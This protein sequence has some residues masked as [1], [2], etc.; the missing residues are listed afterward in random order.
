MDDGQ[1]ACVSPSRL[2]DNQRVEPAAVTGYWQCSLSNMERV[3]DR[4]SRASGAP[5]A[6]C[7]RQDFASLAARRCR[8]ATYPHNR[9]SRRRSRSVHPLP[10]QHLPARLAAG[11]RRHTAG[12]RQTRDTCTGGERDLPIQAP[13]CGKAAIHAGSLMSRYT[14]GLVHLQTDPMALQPGIVWLSKTQKRH[15]HGSMSQTLSQSDRTDCPGPTPLP[16][17]P[18]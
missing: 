8:S 6:L 7:Q 14:S 13:H 16:R 4:E 17:C 10:R 15:H 1:A 11:A 5:Q 2:D 18:L 3:R 12:H 9:R